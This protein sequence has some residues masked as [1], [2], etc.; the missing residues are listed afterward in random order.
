MIRN[1]A[2]LKRAIQVGTEFKVINHCRPSYIGEHRIVTFVNTLGFYS[3]VPER[4]TLSNEDLD[5]FLEWGKA[6]NWDFQNNVCT[7][8]RNKSKHIDSTVLVSFVV[9]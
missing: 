5:L 2:Q 1:L 7:Q 8:Y 9:S 3:V 4:K 6:A